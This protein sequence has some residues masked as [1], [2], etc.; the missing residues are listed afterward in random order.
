L[1]RSPRSA[2]SRGTE[3]RVPVGNPRWGQGLPGT[4][5][6]LGGN[7]P[8]LTEP[9]GSATN[10]VAAGMDGRENPRT[11]AGALHIQ[12]G[13]ESSPMKITVET[14]ALAVVAMAI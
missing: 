12:A 14:L 13:V 3:S 4:A 6:Q 7:H 5:R 2:T 8:P 1:R 11:E 9:D 10:A